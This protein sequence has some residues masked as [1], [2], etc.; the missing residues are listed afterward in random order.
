M[1]KVAIVLVC[2]LV[3][4]G[5]F[6]QPVDLDQIE[7][8]ELDFS[9][10]DWSGARF[11]FAGPVDLFVQGITYMGTE[12]SAVLQ[13]D[14]WETVS[15]A[16][17]RVTSTEGLPR[18][19]DL[20]QIELSLAEDGVAVSNVIAD[21]YYFSGKLVPTPELDLVVAPEIR[22]GRSAAAPDQSAQVDGLRREVNDLRRRLAAAESEKTALE[23]A[24][25][26]AA[27]E[28]ASL[29]RQL[30]DAKA[31]TPTTT[32]VRAP[33]VPATTAAPGL[34]SLAT[35]VRS[36]I[37]GVNR[38]VLSGFDG[39]RP[40]LGS[41]SVAGN[42]LNQSAADQRFAK[43]RVPVSQNAD[44]LVY[45]F[46][47]TGQ[48]NGWSGYGIHILASGATNERLYGHG[49]SYLVW[50]TRDPARMHSDQTFVQLYR[51]TSDTQMVQVASVAVDQP[52]STPLDITVYVN[53]PEQRIILGV[54]NEPLF[55][56][57]D[58][59][60]IGSGTDVVARAL[61]RATLNTLSV[62]TR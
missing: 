44:E 6:G 39:G 48:A 7:L 53:R 36:A 2:L 22:M 12:Y 58:A 62:K 31:A 13:Y 34:A 45:T 17:P 49:S 47:G 9:Q 25:A 27:A 54:G 14:G 40:I 18:M 43:Y 20:S 33:A 52:I 37:A 26:A 35:D 8:S 30:A 42:Q 24:Q 50:V 23:A 57:A 16:S 10:A 29:E 55:S 59:N 56:Y 51:S 28:K 1:K 21:G 4:M 60:M 41:W 61:G 19:L 11:Y 38:V 46:S 3:S 5:A 32:V 15:I